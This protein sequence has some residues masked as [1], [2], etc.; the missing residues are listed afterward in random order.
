MRIASAALIFAFTYAQVLLAQVDKRDPPKGQQ[1]KTGSSQ[2]VAARLIEPS[3]A[4][5]EQDHANYESHQTNTFTP[6]AKDESNWTAIVGIAGILTAVWTVLEIK[7]QSRI[8]SAAAQAAQ[9]S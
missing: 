2:P 3:P 5:I 6:S 1:G 8:S 4:P 7:K 9:A